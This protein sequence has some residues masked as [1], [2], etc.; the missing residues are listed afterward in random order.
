VAIDEKR[1]KFG[2]SLWDRVPFPPARKSSKC[3][4]PVRTPMS[5]VG[6][7]SGTAQKQ[8][9]DRLSGS[10]MS[11]GNASAHPALAP[12]TRFDRHDLYLLDLF[13]FSH[14]LIQKVCNFFKILLYPLKG[15]ATLNVLTCGGD[16]RELVLQI[17]RSLASRPVRRC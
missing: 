9:Y 8:G 6:T 4:L 16:H 17:D 5:A 11:E 12:R 1:K 14:D 3:G 10:T 15:T 13:V 7:T 2:V